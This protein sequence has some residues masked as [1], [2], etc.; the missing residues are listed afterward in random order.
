MGAGVRFC[1]SEGGKA[2]RQRGRAFRWDCGDRKGEVGLSGGMRLMVA[3]R[4]L[5]WLKLEVIS[6]VVRL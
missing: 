4:V 2:C 6:G 3:F 5:R 1:E